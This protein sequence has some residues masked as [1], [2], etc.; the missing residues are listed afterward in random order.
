MHVWK[1]Q[2]MNISD[3]FLCCWPHVVTVSQSDN[4]AYAEALTEALK[5]C[6]FSV[7]C[8]YYTAPSGRAEWVSE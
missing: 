6:L 7:V 5:C 3:V 8:I 2:T 4:D 1:D